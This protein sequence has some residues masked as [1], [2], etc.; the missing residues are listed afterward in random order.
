MSDWVNETMEYCAR[1]LGSG[2]TS[3]E[4]GGGGVTLISPQEEEERGL[5]S[6][7]GSSSLR[8]TTCFLISSSE[9]KSVTSDSECPVYLCCGFLLSDGGLR[10][11]LEVL[12]LAP[13]TAPALATLLLS[14]T[15]WRAT[16]SV[17]ALSSSDIGTEG[18]GACRVKYSAFPVLPGDPTLRPFRGSLQSLAALEP[19]RNI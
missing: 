9:V 5:T 19:L 18:R 16:N 2:D 12:G 11:W 10:Y 13:P 3:V 1:R 4:A 14:P 7:C 8:V 6:R 15:L 17:L